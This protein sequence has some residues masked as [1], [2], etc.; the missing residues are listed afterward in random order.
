M[1]FGERGWSVTTQETV[2]G[3]RLDLSFEASGASVVVESKLGA[4]TDLAQCRKYIEHL[5]SRPGPRRALVLLTKLEEPWPAGIEKIAAAHDV[6]LVTRRWWNVTSL[7]RSTAGALANDFADML[8]EEGLVI[9]GPLAEPD[10][11]ASADVPAAAVALLTELKPKLKTLS[12]GFRRQVIARGR[13]SSYRSLYCLAYFA[14]A[15]IGP[16]LSASWADLAAHRR[17]TAIREP[18]AGPII[19]CSVLNPTLSERER[20]AAAAKAVAAAGSDVAGTCWG[21][22]PTCASPAASILTATT[23]LGQVE[24]AFDYASATAEHFRDIGYLDDLP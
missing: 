17:L 3:G 9:P 13:D 16:G 6:R 10:W 23:F 18:L 8:E 14:R 12:S 15:Q 20:P 2:A 19:A 5:A 4:S 1:G 7:L 21:K 24:Q 22:F 11:A